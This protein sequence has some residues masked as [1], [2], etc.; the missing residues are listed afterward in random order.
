MIFLPYALYA[1]TVS[2]EQHEGNEAW[3]RESR[4]MTLAFELLGGS[5]CEYDNSCRPPYARTRGL[6]SLE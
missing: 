1:P 5:V 6:V 4:M 3:K 2:L